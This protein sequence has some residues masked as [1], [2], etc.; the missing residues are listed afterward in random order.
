M[1]E[2]AAEQRARRA[3]LHTAKVGDTVNYSYACGS[4]S[5][6]LLVTDVTETEIICSGYRFDRNTGNEINEI[7]GWDEFENP[8]FI[9]VDE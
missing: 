1:A 9:M 2:L 8:S 5:R 7:I 3:K 6:Q 4:S